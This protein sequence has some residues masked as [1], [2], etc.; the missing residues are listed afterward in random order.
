MKGISVY[1]YVIILTIWFLVDS[2]SFLSIAGSV[3][4]VPAQLWAIEDRLH[5]DISSGEVIAIPLNMATFIS[6]CVLPVHNSLDQ[7]EIDQAQLAC[8][9]GQDSSAKYPG[10]ICLFYNYHGYIYKFC[11][12]LRWKPVQQYLFDGTSA[13]VFRVERSREEFTFQLV[14]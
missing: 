3:Q 7:E 5:A 10:V 13:P 4:G 12:G 8:Q 11:K 2:V 6:D 9:R 1:V 14:E